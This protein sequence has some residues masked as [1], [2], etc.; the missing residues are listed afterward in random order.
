VLL[1]GKTPAFQSISVV[2]LPSQHNGLSAIY[3]LEYTC[4]ST[5]IVSVPTRAHSLEYL[6]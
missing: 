2:V 6:G 3:A 5:E 4:T 1:A